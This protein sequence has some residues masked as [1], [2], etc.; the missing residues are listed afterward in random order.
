MHPGSFCPRCPTSSAVISLSSRSS[1][2][3]VPL[4]PR[5]AF[6]PPSFTAGDPMS[7]SSPLMV[8]SPG[9][10]ASSPLPSL[11]SSSPCTEQH[12]SGVMFSAAQQ[13]HPFLWSQQWPVLSD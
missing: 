6:L 4:E 10:S 1:L 12:T 2:A 13:L 5:P 3:L 9:G 8:D 7:P 11:S